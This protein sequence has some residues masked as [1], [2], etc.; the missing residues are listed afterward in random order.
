[1]SGWLSP[2]SYGQWLFSALRRHHKFNFPIGSAVVA[3]QMNPE[4]I[5]ST[6]PK[7]GDI[8]RHLRYCSSASS[9]F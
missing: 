7:G 2:F 8:A 1:M 9:L 4:R 3:V 5:V 6:R